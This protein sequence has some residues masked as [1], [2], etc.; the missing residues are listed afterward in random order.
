MTKLEIFLQ[1][2]RARCLPQL[3][4]QLPGCLMHRHSQVWHRHSKL[5]QPH[6]HQGM[7]QCEAQFRMLRPQLVF[8]QYQLEW[9]SQCSNAR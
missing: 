2:H 6:R 5:Q 1:V 9:G 7:E 3:L 8:Q 4:L